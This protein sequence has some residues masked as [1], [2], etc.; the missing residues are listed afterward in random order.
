MIDPATGALELHPAYRAKAAKALM[1]EVH[2]M[3]FR[4]KLR[5]FGLYFRQFALDI[6]RARLLAESYFLCN[7][8]NLRGFIGHGQ[9]PH[10]RHTT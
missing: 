8:S 4:L 7:F 9:L 2:R 5:L 10:D 1:R 6:R 3:K